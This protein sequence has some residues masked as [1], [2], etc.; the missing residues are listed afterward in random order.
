[1]GAQRFTGQ[2]QAFQR[3]I[4]RRMNVIND[5]ES[6]LCWQLIN[7]Q[8][9]ILQTVGAPR[10]AINLNAHQR[11]VFTVQHQRRTGGA[12]AFDFADG[13]NPGGLCVQIEIQIDIGG[14]VIWRAIIVAILRLWLLCH[15]NPSTS[16]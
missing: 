12:L 10:L 9:V 14:G 7:Q 4:F 2:V 11:Q 15:K 1:M 13:G 16:Q 3:G 5:G 6:K 8:L